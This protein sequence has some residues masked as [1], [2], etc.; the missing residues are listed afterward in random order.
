M[1][2]HALK[3]VARRAFLALYVRNS[4]PQSNHKAATPPAPPRLSALG[5]VLRPRIRT[6]TPSI[7]VR[8]RS[9][10]QAV[11]SPGYYFP[12]CENPRHSR[13]LGWH[14]PVS[15]RQFLPFRSV[16]GGFWA[17]VSGCHF[18]ISI[19]VRQRPVRLLTETGLRSALRVRRWRSWRRGGLV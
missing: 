13:G 6:L 11:G 10:S 1:P 14:A 8:I 9:L 12:M 17:P 2:D 4:A 15:V 5:R 7:M 16:R 19:S 18:S 3:P